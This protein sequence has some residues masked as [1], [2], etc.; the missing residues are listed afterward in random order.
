MNRTTMKFAPDEM[1][2]LTFLHETADGQKVRAEVV[3]KIDDLIAQN[4]KEIMMLLRSRII[5]AKTARVRC[6]AV[7]PQS[8]LEKS[9]VLS[10]LSAAPRVAAVG[11]F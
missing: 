3:Q 8:H 1:K 4:H 10:K 7:R 11:S 6:G 2:G 5:E 9:A